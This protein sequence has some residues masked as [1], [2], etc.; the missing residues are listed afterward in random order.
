MRGYFGVTDNEWFS[1]LAQQPGIDEVNFWQPGGSRLF[2][3]LEPQEP[4]LFKLH[5]PLNFIAGGGFFAHSTILPVSLA[6]QAFQEKNGAPSY[7]RMKRL[8]ERIR[9]AS[10]QFEDY[11][12]GCIILTQPFFFSREQWFPIPPDFSLN[13]VQGKGYDL[14]HGHGQNLWDQVLSR[15]PFNDNSFHQKSVMADPGKRYGEPTR[16]AKI[17]GRGVSGHGDGCL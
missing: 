17:R 9:K 11:K 2:K 6:W 12:I 5:S 16:S 8:I 13:I 7:L 14:A 3:S 1:F 4:F 10:S 15:L